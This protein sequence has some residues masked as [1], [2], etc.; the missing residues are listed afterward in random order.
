MIKSL[1]LTDL[2]K[3]DDYI[4]IGIRPD[5]AVASSNS[6]DTHL[7]GEV[8]IV[9]HAGSRRYARVKTDTGLT[10]KV[11]TEEDLKEGSRAYVRIKK[12]YVFGSSGSRITTIKY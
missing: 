4:Y 7:S 6:V 5:E 2:V 3:D 1:G 11:L 10:L 9:E 12:M 8:V